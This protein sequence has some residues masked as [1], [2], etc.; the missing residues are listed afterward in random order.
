MVVLASIL[1]AC[2]NKKDGTAYRLYHNMTAHYNGYFNAE[3]ILRKGQEKISKEYK[4]DYDA[5]L[6]LYIL[7]TEEQ[8]KS[9]YPDLEK[10]ITKCEK[11]IKRHTITDDSQKEKKHPKLNRWIDDNYMVIGRAHYYKSNFGRAT[12]AFQYVNR[13]FKDPETII[14]SNVWLCKTFIRKEEYSRALQSLVRAEG[15]A[16]DAEVDPN[17]RAEY[18]LAYA[19]LLIHQNKLDKAAEKLE[20][21]IELISKKKNCARPHF[22]LA[23]VYQRLSRNSDALTHYE[24][25]LQSKPSFELEFYARINRAMSYSRTGGS[26]AMIRK[27]LNKMLSDEKNKDYVDQI[28][29]ALGELSWEEQNRPEAID[30]FKK[31]VSSAT[32]NPKQKAKAF[33]RLADLFFDERKYAQAETYYDSTLTKIN[34]QHPRYTEIKVRAESLSE[35]VGYLDAI[36]MYDS[37]NTICGLSEADRAVRLAEISKD[38]ARQKEEQRIEDERLAAE[39]AAAAA[40]N[41]ISGTFWCYNDQLTERGKTEFEDYWGSRPLKDNWRLQSRLSQDFG[42]GEEEVVVEAV[43]GDSAQ[44]EEVD[45]Y[46]APTPEEL[47]AALPCD[48]AGELER[49]AADAAEGY[50]QAGLVY[51]EKLEDEDNATSTWEELL[52]NMEN[53]SYHPTTYY[54]LFRTWLSK[55]GKKGFVK[56]PLCESCNSAYWAAEIKRLYPGSDW[57]MLVD[58]PGF[59]DIQDLKK[60]QEDSAY[61]VVYSKYTSRNYIGAVQACD[62]VLANEPQNHLLCKYRLL[63]VVCIGY[64]DGQFGVRDRYLS[65]LNTLIQQCP[66]TEEA[67]RAQQLIDGLVGEKPKGEGKKDDETNPNPQPSSDDG[68]YVFDGSAEH[69]LGVIL[70]VKDVNVENIK[71]Q[72]SDF[73]ALYFNSAQLKVSSNLLD[74][75]HHL[76]LIKSFK[77]SEER[78]NYFGTF[79]A[80]KEK[81]QEINNPA[82][83]IF[84]ISKQNYITLFKSKDIEQYI[85]F[86]TKYY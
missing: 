86:Y 67:T 78:G 31:S 64:Q 39:A 53:S 26:S 30:Y 8:Q 35:L 52:A 28:Y 83:R 73:N 51:K 85:N 6:P 38:I 32:T 77:N 58:N 61:R 18:Y 81:L 40:A 16:E 62:S 45:P 74:K 76:V 50:Y 33:L 17:I 69:Y 68:P 63:R 29:Y 13:K 9:N 72:I 44:T 19:D 24:M 7:G 23:Q 43:P 55:E 47:A 42:P 49:I 36:A 65:E 46:K 21:A 25:V 56:N 14:Q 20:D 66:G 59:L 48:D 10:A 71:K 41:Q 5:I 70:P 4:E 54:Q 15:E 22:I 60:Q 82:N 84:L 75:D 2:S 27:E 11:V 12:E 80:D 79:I 3:E 57:A 1:W 34:E 37:L